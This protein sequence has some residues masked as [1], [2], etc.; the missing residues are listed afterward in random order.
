MGEGVI[1]ALGWLKNG[2]V[3]SIMLSV[4]WNLEN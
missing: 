4:S 2:L 1:V 3:S